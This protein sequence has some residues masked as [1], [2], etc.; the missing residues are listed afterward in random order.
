MVEDRDV[1]RRVSKRESTTGTKDKRIFIFISPLK[2]KCD[3]V[4]TLVQCTVYRTVSGR[5]E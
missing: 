2:G 1:W 5:G 3:G 4:P